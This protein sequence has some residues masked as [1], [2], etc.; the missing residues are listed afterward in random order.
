[1]QLMMSGWAIR[2]F[3]PVT[4]G[5][6][7]SVVVH[8]VRFFASMGLVFYDFNW[9]SRR[10][11]DGRRCKELHVIAALEFVLDVF[12]TLHISSMGRAGQ[13]TVPLPGAGRKAW[14]HACTELIGILS[15]IYTPGEH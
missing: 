4:Y 12:T 9:T 8:L 3:S 15:S 1:M 2:W 5:R 14:M 7:L 11:K 10:L 13:Q 6:I